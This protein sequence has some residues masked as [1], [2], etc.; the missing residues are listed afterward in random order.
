M[1]ILQWLLLA[2]AV[3]TPPRARAQGQA[4]SLPGCQETCGNLTIPYPFG[5]TQDCSLNTSFLITCNNSI[6]YIRDGI[7][8]LDI[9]LS[10]HLR[11]SAPLASDCYDSRGNRTSFVQQS[12]L[13]S[14]FPVSGKLN[15][16]TAIGCD[17]NAF[18]FIGERFMTGCMSLCVTMDD[19]I[20]GSCSGIGCCQTAIPKGFRDF[21]ITVGSYFS[22]RGIWDFSKCSYA[23][24]VEEKSYK[25]SSLD[26]DK[27]QNVK[28]FPVVLDWAVG[29]TTCDQAQQNRE[30][31]L[32]KENTVCRDFDGGHAL[33][34]QCDCST[35]YQGNPYI[36]NGCQDVDECE[37]GSLHDCTDICVNTGGGY[38]CLCPKGYH[39]S[40]RK[41]E[42]CILKQNQLSR[43]T[44]AV[45]GILGVAFIFGS[46][47]ALYWGYRKRKIVKIKEQFFK[48]NG[49]IMLQ[50]LLSKSKTE[51]S[52]Q[53]GQIFTEQELNEATNNFSASHVVGQGGYGT[54]YKG[55]LAN[56]MV[57]AIK[58]SN[59]V[60]RG[61]IEQ[62]VNEVVV[63]SQIKHPN[64]VKL[65]GCCLE[66]AVPLL[67]YEFITNNTLFHH[68]HNEGFESSMPWDMRL[69]IAAETAGALAHMHSAPMHIIHRDVKSANILLD[70]DYTAKVSDFG[71]SRL[72]PWDQTQ[73]PTLVQGT[74]GYIDP[75]YFHSGLLTKK[76]D[77]Y[78][79]G[80]V[81][82]EL[83]TGQKVVSM[84]RPEKD[85]SLAT[86]FIS[87]LEE[88]RLDQVLETRVRE[89][90]EAEQLKGVAELARKCLKLE[91]DKRPSMK[92]V[93]E[94]LDGLM[95]K[96]EDSWNKI[97]VKFEE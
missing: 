22:H 69:R 58:R 16:F 44:F 50:Q 12:L 15:K 72:V 81:L 51:S 87:S 46:I 92:E 86:Y 68:I 30:S 82:V 48:Q 89:E 11:I 20:N 37:D 55:T 2:A 83:L 3:A 1:L 38:T 45:G 35:G 63:L 56:G 52:I 75:E 29:N 96:M 97:E 6:P 66:T 5:L 42:G 14:T 77:V 60:D 91:G 7:P 10:G 93:K 28:K 59:V 27:M 39:G 26:L 17:T 31:Y 78:S 85:R 25:F 43:T 94:E 18:I 24:V 19:L 54:V 47:T 40:G 80:V 95:G 4:Q 23:F 61:Q 57:V 41:G 74:F 9:S 36:Q 79:F 90:G 34:Y 32:C 70:E 21:S 53:K 64:V 62:F 84:E 8:V 88:D 67:V 33:G 65:L 71:V 73:L 13:L 76:S 49:G